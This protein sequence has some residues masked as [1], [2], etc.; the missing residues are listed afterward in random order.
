LAAGLGGAFCPGGET[1][2]IIRNPAIYSAPYRIRHSASVTTG[3]L[4]QP[5]VLNPPPDT[6]A[7]LAAGLEPGDLTK[8]SGVPW[9]ADF[10]ECSTNPTD[11]TY[12]DWNNLYL[13]GTG[14]P[15][16]AQSWN[17]YW[18]PVHRPMVVNNVAWSPTPQTNAGDTQMVTQW[19]KLGFVVNVPKQGFVLVESGT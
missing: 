3:S 11:V 9:Q 18:W 4:S 15:A 5:G 13:A 12:E 8:Y 19:S 10:N 2:W 17:T 7:N 14:D 6:P 1:C 16:P